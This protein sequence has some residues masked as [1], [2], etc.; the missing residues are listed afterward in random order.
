MIRASVLFPSTDAGV[1]FQVIIVV[2]LTVVGLWLARRSKDGVLFV[3]GLS[4]MTFAF[5]GLRALH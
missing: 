2:L 3:L 1:G 4:L 5:F